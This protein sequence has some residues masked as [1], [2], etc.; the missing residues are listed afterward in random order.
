MQ[1]PVYNR[2]VRNLTFMII[3]LIASVV[4]T[5][6]VIY[7]SPEEKAIREYFGLPK[8]TPWPIYVILVAGLVTVYILLFKVQERRRRYVAASS[9]AA[10]FL[11]LAL[12]RSF[13]WGGGIT[14]AVML[15]IVVVGWLYPARNTDRSQV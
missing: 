12:F 15:T 4:I 14:I 3:Y 5:F 7:E 8:R 1:W 9:G 6:R 11:Y 10:G 2:K 13:W